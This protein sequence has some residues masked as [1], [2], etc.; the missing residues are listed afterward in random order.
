MRQVKLVVDN[1][2]PGTEQV[3]QPDQSG[4]W[5][6]FVENG[7]RNPDCWDAHKR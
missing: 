5:G 4:D 3:C 1:A 2:G 7:A 6:L